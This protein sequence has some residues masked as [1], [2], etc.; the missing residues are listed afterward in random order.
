M[1]ASLVS[2]A[3]L[4]G[5]SD[6]VGASDDRYAVIFDFSNDYQGWVPGFVDY[7]VGKESEWAIGSSLAPLPAP[8]RSGAQGHSIDGLEPQRRSVHVHHAG[9]PDPRA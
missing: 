4:A 6:S 1:L 3:A 5:C 9:G 2:T 8:A 7:P